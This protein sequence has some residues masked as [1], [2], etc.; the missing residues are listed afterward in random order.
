MASK[1][2]SQSIEYIY[3]QLTV[4]VNEFKTVLD[5]GFHVVDSGFQVLD[6]GHKQWNLDSGFLELYSGFQSPRFRIQ[7]A[8]VSQIPLHVA[9]NNC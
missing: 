7:R 9:K 3:F 8:N 4:H 1:S 5:S 6:S 2:E